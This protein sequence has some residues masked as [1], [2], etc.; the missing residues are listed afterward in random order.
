[1]VDVTIL[2]TVELRLLERELLLLVPLLEGELRLLEGERELE[3]Y[4]C[5]S[6]RRPTFE[7]A[8]PSSLG[9]DIC[10]GTTIM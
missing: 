6:S 9:G 5:S 2:A 4:V 7:A 8:W 3:A 1:M 10:G